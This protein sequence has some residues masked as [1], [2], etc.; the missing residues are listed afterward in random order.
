M[1]GRRL[2]LYQQSRF[3]RY[4]MNCRLVEVVTQLPPAV[5]QNLLG[6]LTVMA[7]EMKSSNE[8][9]SPSEQTSPK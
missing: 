5:Q 9:P 4:K 6:L 1:E 7:N 3:I 8:D 2:S